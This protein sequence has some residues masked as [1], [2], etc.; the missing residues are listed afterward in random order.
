MNSVSILKNYS[1]TLAISLF[2]RLYAFIIYWVSSNEVIGMDITLT[3]L[4]GGGTM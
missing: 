2:L 4:S 1:L 3:T